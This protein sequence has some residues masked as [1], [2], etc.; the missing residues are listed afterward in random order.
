MKHFML[1]ITAQERCIVCMRPPALFNLF[2]PCLCRRSLVGN[3]TSRRPGGVPRSQCL[4]FI[5]GG[6]LCNQHI[7]AEGMSDW[8]D[9]QSA[10][11]QCASGLHWLC[12]F[13][14]QYNQRNLL[15][16]VWVYLSTDLN[17]SAGQE[18]TARPLHDANAGLFSRLPG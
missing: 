9:I 3:A 18:V 5:S 2:W 17:L 15:K 12:L 6:V 4:N 13:K 11:R 8:M 16:P 14:E 10:F 7:R 1:L